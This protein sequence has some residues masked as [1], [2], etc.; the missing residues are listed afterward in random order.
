MVL[1][2]K[3]LRLSFKKLVSYFTFFTS[4]SMTI[5]SIYLMKL[6][7]IFINIAFTANFK[8]HIKNYLFYYDRD[9]DKSL[10]TFI[11]S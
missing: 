11:S 3:S 9:R 2:N 6:P 7:Q 8:S 5:F 1:D 4:N 10:N